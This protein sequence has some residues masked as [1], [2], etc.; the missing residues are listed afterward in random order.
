M[1]KDLR[2]ENLS[3]RI[4]RLRR[5]IGMSQN[6]L[7]AKVGLSSRTI[8]KLETE[9]QKDLMLQ[10]AI[11][12]AQALDVSLEYLAFGEDSLSLDQAKIIALLRLLD[13]GS[14]RTLL[15]T[16]QAL[17]DMRPAVNQKKVRT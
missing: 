8:Q 16:A 15:A 13:S 14:V 17:S 2:K 3:K 6:D 1:Q 9:L 11:A 10:N 5:S 4:A 12:I 7:A